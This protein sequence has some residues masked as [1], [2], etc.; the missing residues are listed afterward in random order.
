[1]QNLTITSVYQLWSCLDLSDFKVFR[2]VFGSESSLRFF[3]N[4]LLWLKKLSDSAL[5]Q[6][7]EWSH[8]NHLYYRANRAIGILRQWKHTETLSH[9][10]SGYRPSG[11]KQC[12][13]YRPHENVHQLKSSVRTRRVFSI[14][15]CRKERTGFFITV[16]RRLVWC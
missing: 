12:K 13:Q 1:M 10:H 11:A 4:V 3:V 14:A 15:C 6:C 9:I 5:L 16:N 8:V 7:W 2:K